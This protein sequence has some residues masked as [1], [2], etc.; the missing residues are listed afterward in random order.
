MK[1]KLDEILQENH[2]SDYEIKGR[3]KNIY[4]V[5][6]KMNTKNKD[7]E[8]IYDL[9][10][11]RILVPT[12]EDCYHALGLVHAEWTPIPMR[13]KDYIATPKTNGYQS[14]HTTVITP[15]HQVVEFGV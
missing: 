1:L 7:F 15:E 4:S 6:K 13:F 11:L 14:L 10:A 2:I 5:C 9:L 12:I 3:I 8:Q